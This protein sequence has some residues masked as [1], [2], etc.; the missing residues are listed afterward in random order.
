MHLP[1]DEREGRRTEKYTFTSINKKDK[2][3]K[4]K[5]DLNTW[6]E[7]KVGDSIDVV[8]SAGK[9]KEIKGLHREDSIVEEN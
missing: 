5:V 7:L 6:Q 4:Y 1:E 2:E 8:L 3:K 9:I